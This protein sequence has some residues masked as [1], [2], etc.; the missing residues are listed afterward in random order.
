MRDDRPPFRRLGALVPLI[1]VL[2]SAVAL[3]AIILL[4]AGFEEGAAAAGIL[5]LILLAGGAF[6][7]FIARRALRRNQGDVRLADA[8]STDPVPA[9]VVDDRAPL[10]ATGDTHSELIPEDLPRDHPGRAEV[11]RRFR[12]RP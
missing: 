9:V 6:D 8:D 4:V 3:I 1:V 10:G 12:A 2:A 5:F 11:E 7:I